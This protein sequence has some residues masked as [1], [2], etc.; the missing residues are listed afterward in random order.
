N[1]AFVEQSGLTAEEA[2]GKTPT[3]I[4]VWAVP[5]M[6][7][8]LLEQLQ[9]GNIRNLEVPLRRKDGQT[10]SG[11]M[12]AQPFKL[13][14][15]PAVLVVVRDIT[16]LKQ[17]QRQLQLSEEKFAKAFHA[18]PDGLT[19]SRV[20]DGVILEVNDGFCRITGYTEKQCFECSTLELGIWA[21]LSERQTMIR[22]IKRHGSIHDF[23]VRI[24]GSEGNI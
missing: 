12:S 7:P 24:R 18:S 17:A 9:K 19:I 5:G 8:G 15:K 3:Q 2:I 20:C 16:P 14:V 6:G 10:F 21:D 4:N 23:R 11:L 1:K 22:H 13:G